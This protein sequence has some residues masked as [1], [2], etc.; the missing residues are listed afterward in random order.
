MLIKL[1]VSLAQIDEDVQ[2]HNE[3]IEVVKAN[4]SGIGEIVAK[5]RKDFTQEF[6]VHLHNVAQSYMEDK[7]KQSGENNLFH[8]FILMYCSRLFF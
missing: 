6:F 4:P 2:R 7:A 8:F 5:R 3:L 1:G